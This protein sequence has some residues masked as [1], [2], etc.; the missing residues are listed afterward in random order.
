MDDSVITC[1]D[2]IDVDVEAKLYHEAKSCN[3]KMKTKHLVKHKISTFY[4]HF[5]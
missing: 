5:Y 4:L 1:D 2:I 3:D